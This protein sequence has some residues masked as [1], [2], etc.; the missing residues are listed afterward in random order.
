M[1]TNDNSPWRCPEC[2]ELERQCRCDD[3]MCWVC[4]CEPCQCHDDD[5]EWQDSFIESDFEDF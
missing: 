5:A 4:H 2:G 1:T 3:A